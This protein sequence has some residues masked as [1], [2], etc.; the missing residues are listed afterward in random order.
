LSTSDQARAGSTVTDRSRA[1]ESASDVPEIQAIESVAQEMHD[2][3]PNERFL[4]FEDVLTGLSRA[5]QA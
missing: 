5:L 1:V 3:S 2:L 4:L